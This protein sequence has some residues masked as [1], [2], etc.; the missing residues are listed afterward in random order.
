MNKTLEVIEKQQDIDE[1]LKNA[2]NIVA[3]LWPLNNFVAVNPFLGELDNSFWETSKHFRELAHEDIIS[4]ISFF[5][6]A[7]QKG[8]IEDRSISKAIES[9]L[10]EG[11]CISAE[12]VYET[13]QKNISDEQKISGIYSVSDILETKEDMVKEISHWLS[14][15][16][17]KGQALWTMPWK[18]LGLFQAWKEIAKYDKRVVLLGLG[19]LYSAFSDGPIDSKDY[20]VYALDKLAVPESFQEKYL[21]R[22]FLM[23]PGWSGY[24]Q[25]KVRAS[26]MQGKKDNNLVDFLA[27][28]L[29][30]EIAI[31]EKSDMES[32]YSLFQESGKLE[33]Q[34]EDSNELLVRYTLQK[35]LEITYRK[36]I[37]GK[38]SL[39]KDFM[40]SKRPSLQA[41]F[42]IDVRSE[43]IRRNLES[44]SPEI[45]TLGFAGF[46]GFPIG[47]QPVNSEEH[48]ARCP[49]LLNP[50]YY[51]KEECKGKKGKKQFEKYIDS[52]KDLRIWNVFKSLSIAS[53][54]FVEAFG[55]LYLFKLIY[56]LAG[57]KTQVKAE[58]DFLFP[59][60]EYRSEDKLGIPFADK[61]NLAKSALT[62]MGL[63][64]NFAPTVLI[65]GHGSESSNNPYASGL[66]C[67]ACG[68]HAGDSNARVAVSVLNDMKVREILKEKGIEIPEDTIFVAG[69]HNTT[70]DEFVL[71]DIESLDSEKIEDL[72]RLLEEAGNK[73]RLE[74]AGKLG[75]EK[76]IH[77]S[78]F[79][80]AFD[81]SETRPE[82][83]LAGNAAFIA[84]PRA[85]SKD[86]NLEGRVFLHN[87]NYKK[88][89]DAKIL[90][91]IMT[92]PLVVAS[93]INMQYYASS[94]NNDYFGSGNKTIHNLIGKFAVMLGNSGDIRVG[95]PFQSV[96]DGNSLYHKP[97]RL[98]AIIAAPIDMIEEVLKKHPHV[99]QLF[100]NKW[101][102][103]TALD[104]KGK[105]YEYKRIEDWIKI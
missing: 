37:Y 91:L 73:A 98:N 102:S 31:L 88:D 20:I 39:E 85:I 97:V 28:L 105:L 104:S 56:K 7:Y 12:S 24:I 95:L 15:Y 34:K 3:P 74:R 32:W 1:L 43:P 92:A 4:S 60:P 87:Y 29:A 78:I 71:Y 10:E 33:T 63:Q 65:C 64:T 61:V 8:D 86:S 66:D 84:A 38:L 58:K 9:V 42:C 76:D 16:Y 30:Y 41:V 100:D 45:E 62:N 23:I 47:L 79:K 49:V 90:E 2:S 27:I 72:K 40:D 14:A 13:L 93:W 6:E 70:T 81:W 22:L 46:F 75:I 50:V 35:A 80:K 25:Y 101:L 99:R 94:V 44:L 69:L 26:S 48:T 55:I 21:K 59:N 17:D 53:F 77:K 96:H 11:F 19:N 52:I 68:G 36:K 82:W 67:G 103:L 83:G 51:I 54:S 18:Q 5:K 57:K 89:K